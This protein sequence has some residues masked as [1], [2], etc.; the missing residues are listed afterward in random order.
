MNTSVGERLPAII[1]SWNVQM[2]NIMKIPWVE[3]VPG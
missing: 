3:N 1:S 2:L